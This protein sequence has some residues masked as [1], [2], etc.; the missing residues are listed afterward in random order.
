MKRNSG[1]DIVIPVYNALEDLKLCVE[2]IRKH[3]DLTLDR[4]ILIDDRSPDPAVYPYMQSMAREG[5]VVLQNEVNQ[6]FSGT[7]NR[8]LQYSRQ[9]VI[10]LNSDTVVTEGWVD[11]IVACAY[12]DPAIGTVTPFSNNATLCSIPGFC[13]ENTVPYG[14]SV[15]AYARIIERSS[16]KKYPRITVAVGFCMFIKQEVVDRVGLF[17]QETFQRGYGEENDFCWRCEQLGYHHVL[18]DDTYIYHSGSSSFVSDE[19]KKLMADH[20]KIL[21]DRYPQQMQQND[22]YVRDNPHQYLRDNADIYAKL[23]NGRKNI[24]Y[25]L[26]ADF[27]AD[28]SD[29]IGGTQFH[30]KDLVTCGR[31]AHNVFVL[32]R[33]GQM[34]RLTVYLEQEQISFAFRAQRESDFQSF[35]S[36]PIARILSQV[37][38]AFAIDLVHVH[39]VSGISF[40]VFYVAKEMG[41]PVI[42]TMHD[43]YYVCPTVKLLEKGTVYCRGQGG[44]CA[45]CLHRELGFASQVDYLPL[46]RDRCREAMGLCERLIVPSEAVRR[47]YSAIYPELADR[48]CVIPHGMDAF[49]MT[50]EAFVPAAPK[51]N[52]C[53]E[54]AFARNYEISGWVFLEDSDSRGSEIYLRLEDAEGKRALFRARTLNRPDVAQANANDQYTYSGFSLQV[55]DGSFATG[56]LKL[57][58]AIR[59]AEGEFCSP[60]TT[61]TGYRHREK[62]RRRIAF[63]GGLNT[64]KGSQTAYRM[65]RQSGNK[66]DWYIIGGIGDPDLHALDKG[67]VFKTDWYQRENVGAILRDDQIDL[68]C[69]LPICPETFCYTL[70]EAQLAGVPTLVADIGA[71]GDRTRRDGTGWVVSTDITDQQLLDTIEGIFADE[72]G[73]RAMRDTVSAF[74]HKTIAQMYDDYARLYAAIPLPESRADRFDPQM[75]YK[76]WALCQAEKTGYGT[77]G[78][79][80]LIQ[81]IQEL[82]N[83]LGAIEGSFS[84]RVFRKLQGKKIPFKRQLKAMAGAMYRLYRKM[85]GKK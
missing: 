57:Q 48:I 69:I 29:N 5:I 70:S 71:L 10:L 26:H 65:I 31:K 34:L 56:D 55:P 12:S 15:D 51:V 37:M 9:D 25:L 19:K 36:E 39:H 67:N 38:S 30:V 44:D 6:G 21:L 76:A 79:V 8:G 78:D 74:R 23:A 63:L 40:D 72:A 73:Y 46:W 61:V 42:L 82:E 62:K 81:R 58:L 41:I 18:C 3:T 2:S 68:V 66:Y 14:L 84:Y 24:L 27:R 7:V 11:K 47:I 54:H 45:G 64:A 53:I 16:L 77:G 17:D 49:A 20:E 85:K 13:Q 4:L 59:N 43:F 52:F 80:E 83:T 75:I 60:V 35:R 32:A 28:A 22:E 33:D 1:I 50:A